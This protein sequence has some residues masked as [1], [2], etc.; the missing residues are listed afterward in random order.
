MSELR[1][2]LVYEKTCP[3][4]EAARAQLTR[5]FAEAGM[6]PHWQSRMRLKKFRQRP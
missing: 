2:E 1:V 6:P 5:A 4:I 3:N